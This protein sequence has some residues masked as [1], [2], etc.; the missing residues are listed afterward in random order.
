VKEWRRI[1]LY[2][3]ETVE[4]VLGREAAAVES[5]GENFTNSLIYDEATVFK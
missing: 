2:Q 3:G 4:P 1:H 5:A